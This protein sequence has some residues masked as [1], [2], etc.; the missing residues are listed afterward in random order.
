MYDM[1]SI[2]LL[3]PIS[4]LSDSPRRRTS[5]K[6]ESAATR[7]QSSAGNMNISP[8]PFKPL[9]AGVFRTMPK[10]NNERLRYVKSI[11]GQICVEIAPARTESTNG[12]QETAYMRQ[13]G[14]SE[15]VSDLSKLSQSEPLA[16]RT[17]DIAQGNVEEQE[18]M[19]LNLSP[20]GASG[21][22]LD[23]MRIASLSHP[24]MGP[25]QR[26]DQETLK[27]TL[28]EPSSSVA[29]DM[30]KPSSHF[31]FL[32]HRPVIS[33]SRPDYPAE[34]AQRALIA[35]TVGSGYDNRQPS[36]VTQT[37]TT[38]RNL[39]LLQGS[40]RPSSPVS[41]APSLQSSSPMLAPSSPPASSSPLV[42]SSPS[43]LDVP[44]SVI[45]SLSLA[46]AY[47]ES[48][49]SAG[50]LSNSAG[51]NVSLPSPQRSPITVMSGL[52]VELGE[53]STFQE[54]RGNVCIQIIKI[55]ISERC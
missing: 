34:D 1:I 29:E 39:S 21:E 55:L 22:I 12:G 36:D 45:P 19:P 25:K 26:G 43:A 46:E 5:D 20:H 38:P 13:E 41:Y 27:Y 44:E 37:P 33:Q 7:E 50:K 10:A 30:E 9:E 11:A 17:K 47:E 52:G 54:R 8:Q 51:G 40:S 49:S 53:A 24:P 6:D 35:L 16:H 14:V 48:A 3:S 32:G 2:A 23:E 28:P 15:P 42:P 31:T 18:R 4:S